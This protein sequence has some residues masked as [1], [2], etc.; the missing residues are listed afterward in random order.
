[1]AEIYDGVLSADMDW[2]KIMQQGIEY[3]ASGRAVQEFIKNSLSDL[4]T[5]KVGYLGLK[6]S[7]AEGYHYLCAFKDRNDYESWI[8]G[9]MDIGDDLV[10][11][12]VAIPITKSTETSY[13]VSLKN[14]E[15]SNTIVST[16]NTVKIKVRF[17]SVIYNPVDDSTEDFAETGTLRV[18]T[19]LNSNEEWKEVVIFNNIQPQPKD[20]PSVFQEIDITDYLVQGTQQVRM[21]VKGNDSEEYSSYLTYTVTKTNLGL[22]FEN[23][24]NIPQTSNYMSLSYKITGAVSKTL[25]IRVYGNGDGEYLL[26]TVIGTSIYDETSWNVKLYDKSSTNYKVSKQGIHNIEA[27]I[28]VDNSTVES[29]HVFSQ[30]L[31]VSDASSAEPCVIINNLNTELTNWTVQHMFDYALYSPQESTIPLTISLKDPNNEVEYLRLEEA[32]VSTGVIRNFSNT[33]EIEH[34]EEMIY[35]NLTIYS[36]DTMLTSPIAFTINNV[37]GYSPT[38]DADFI[39]NPRSRSNDEE[40]PKVIFNSAEDNAVVNSTWTNFS[41]N[42]DG[43]IT[44]EDNNKCLRVLSGQ[45][46]IIDYP[47]FRNLNEDSCTIELSLTTRNI[48]NEDVPVLRITSEDETTGFI[49]NPLK[50]VFY[51]SGRQNILTQDIDIKEDEMT[52]IAINILKNYTEKTSGK[53]INLVRIFVNGV[54]NREYDFTSSDVINDDKESDY[55]KIRIGNIRG[56]QEGGADIDI[57]GIRIYK[58]QLSSTN[59]MQDYISSLPTVEEKENIKTSNDIL[60]DDNRIS[61]DKAKLKYNTLLWKPRDSALTQGDLGYTT[62]LATYGDSKST[63]QYGDLVITIFKNNG[64]EKDL[65]R[66][67]VINDMTVKGQ[68]TSSM[69]YWKWNQ[70]WEFTD[71][72]KFTPESYDP[73]GED[74]RTASWQPDEG[75]PYAKRLDGKINWASP[76]QTHKMGATSLYNDMWKKVVGGNEITETPG[77]QEFTGNVEGYSSCRVAVIQR[78]FLVFE[79]KT[80]DSTPVFAGM[81]TMGP[82][83]GDKP[84]FGYNKSKWPNFIMF[85][86]CDN[87]TELVNG[88]TPW[89]D[90]DVGLDDAGEIFVHN[91]VNQWEISMGDAE[92]ILSN[93]VYEAFKA[94]NNVCY[95][96]NPDILYF[97]GTAE[98]L[99]DSS[100]NTSLNTQMFYWPTAGDKKYYLYR[101]NNSVWVPAGI[102][103]SGDSYEEVDLRAQT[104]FTPSNE[105]YEVINNKFIEGRVKKYKE[106]IVKYVDEEDLRYTMMFIKLIGASD[107]WAKNTYLYNVGVTDSDGVLTSKFRFFQDDLDTIF[108]V[109]NSGYKIKPYYVEE[110]DTYLS[111]GTN[112]TYWNAD[113][114][115][116]YCLA[117]RAWGVSETSSSGNNYSDP[118]M[119]VTMRSILNNMESIGGSVEGCFDKYFSSIVRYFPKIAYNEIASILYENGFANYNEAYTN[120]HNP[121]N[122]CVGDQ[123]Q[124]ERE[125]MHR[126]SIYMS[127]YARSGEF[128]SRD[129]AGSQGALMFRTVAE[130]GNTNYSFTLTPSIW[131]YP[132]MACGTT[133]ILPKISNNSMD[134][135]RIK[136]GEDV[137]FEFNAGQ[138][139][140]SALRGI[141]YFNKIGNWG[142]VATNSETQFSL[143]GERLQEF[144]I[145]DTQEGVIKFASNRL[146]LS[147]NMDNVKKFVIQGET[148][149]GVNIIQGELDLSPIWRASY[150]DVRATSATSVI[151]PE[152]TDLSTLY[153]PNTVSNL[154]L[155]G[156]KKLSSED[157]Y[158]KFNP[159]SIT[160]IYINDMSSSFNTYDIF[161]KCYNANSSIKSLYIDNIDWTISLDEMKYILNINE[162]DLQGKIII[163]RDDNVDFDTKMK[164]LDK[165]GAVDDPNNRL[166]ITYTVNTVNPDNIS[167]KG[168]SYIYIE[169]DYQFSL[170]Y[171]GTSGDAN[172][173]TNILWKVDSTRFGTIN[174]TS[175]V[176]TY[177]DNSNYP[178]NVDR[179]INITCT[180]TRMSGAAQKTVSKQI[181]LYKRF[182]KPGDYVYA[183]GSYSSPDE[184][185]GDKT[186]IGVCIWAEKQSDSITPDTQRRI[187][188]GN[189][190]YKLSG[191]KALDL[192]WGPSE[193]YATNIGQIEYTAYALVS[194]NLTKAKGKKEGSSGYSWYIY[195]S[196]VA[197][198]MNNYL[199]NPQNYALYDIN[200]Q[201]TAKG[202]SNTS[203][204]ITH[205]NSQRSVSNSLNPENYHEEINPSTGTYWAS[206]KEYVENIINS[207]TKETPSYKFLFP[208]ASWCYAYEPTGLK[209]GEVLNDKFKAHKWFLPSCG[210]IVHL[211]YYIGYEDTT[212]S[213]DQDFQYAQRGL[214]AGLSLNTTTLTTGIT[215]WTSTQKTI[216]R[217]YYM[218]I[219]KPSTQSEGLYWR[220]NYD[221][222]GNS[223]KDN[224]N[225]TDTFDYTVI[226]AVEF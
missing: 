76:M 82:S 178:N 17:Q 185:M 216:E 133:E 6:T 2:G 184:D 123:Y 64:T 41:L 73:D 39:F 60:G 132:S 110:H 160:S 179:T 149:V 157:A 118:K 37:G 210:E 115:A 31:M 28:T 40:N 97:Q 67:G 144:I 38:A 153:L 109:E 79:Q 44:D 117:E 87:N 134:P 102:N 116:L 183:D 166:Y 75:Q 104:G 106:E 14:M 74:N 86:G 114:N 187:A 156:L 65:D 1:M 161:K 95:S 163:Q 154:R 222:S 135:I 63:L 159:S 103:H 218:P 35:A 141:N 62:R 25:N 99:N 50:G 119:V 55:K 18:E 177:K 191:D 173:F 56:A 27:W 70:R 24:W 212:T 199:T 30:V 83:K 9:S 223:H 202:K 120:P 93:P 155:V 29:E 85:E 219:K 130:N 7:E 92:N 59:I 58:R 88:R 13:V 45:E 98:D 188:L 122:Q 189:I 181:F 71:T 19:R 180:I 108:S 89:N 198:V 34:N 171:P 146:T 182:A 15:S 206:E 158:F 142:N 90:E 197:E 112:K 174:P 147:Q 111:G 4:Q 124:G 54:I 138:D 169:Q 36:N 78:P 175:G 128:A 162:C 77:G 94:M 196:D 48:S 11:S 22:S 193:D 12:Y 168:Y 139:V 200:P 145:D 127:S 194:G 207:N 143:T 170:N 172:D 165:F 126:R 226:P 164:M 96:C 68:G 21:R 53:S 84:T 217:A 131:L 43:W 107:N 204:I 225:C 69:T 51:T 42:R 91:G 23:T 201:G 203:D 150:I 10:L 8:S 137:S 121:L 215:V 213:T 214:K 46:L 190:R 140:N 148:P 81:F 221:W 26:Q 33:I 47:V 224:T 167:I 5:S 80:K 211:L 72:S 3:Q 105:S 57:Y 125:W 176:F 129:G 152:K 208:A 32:S 220:C 192:I 66:S 101:Y 49:L 209:T 205:R 61:Y 113:H 195:M 16:D 136:A 52:H 186:V 100:K 151:L 20:S